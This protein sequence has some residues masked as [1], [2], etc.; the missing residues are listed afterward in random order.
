MTT[1]KALSSTTMTLDSPSH[2]TVETPTTASTTP[3]AA[4]SSEPMSRKK[5]KRSLSG[6][7]ETMNNSR[8]PSS[9]TKS[10]TKARQAAATPGA[11]KQQT[12]KQM[13]Q[14]PKESA[15]AKSASIVSVLDS[16]TAPSETTTTPPE[17]TT[18][19]DSKHD[20]ATNGNKAK[21]TMA[22]MVHDAILALKDRTGSSQIAI[23]K[24]ILATFPSVDDNN[25][26]RSRL[27]QTLK[28]GVAS[29]HFQKVK[30]SYKI[31]PEWIKKAKA[32]RA[33]EIVRKAAEKKKRDSA[34][35]A[36]S[37]KK[38]DADA[39]KNRESVSESMKESMTQEELDEIQ[40]KHDLK[41]ER[42]RLKEEMARKEKEKQERLKRRRFPMEDT[43]LHEEDKEF[44][45][46]ATVKRRPAIPYFFQIVRDSKSTAQ[47]PSRC[48][49]VDF[50]NRGLVPDL[51][52]VYHFFRGDVRFCDLTEPKM[53]CDFTLSNLIYSVDEVL[54][55]NA[56]K[57]KLVPPLLQHLFL[58]CLSLLTAPAFAGDTRE[59]KQLSRDLEELADALSPASWP[60]ICIMYMECMDRYY[61]SPASQDPS[62]LP[63]GRTDV[64]Y[65]FR[66]SDTLSTAPVPPGAAVPDGYFGY[67]GNPKSTLAKAFDKLNRQ[68]VWTL[69]AD[70]LMALLRA[71]TDD[72]I[73]TRPD[74]MVE[75]SGRCVFR[76]Q[77]L[78][79]AAPPCFE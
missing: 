66:V 77:N 46:T 12:D 6:R 8:T 64:S 73:A 29:S 41:M 59:Q 51:L 10:A 44:G 14:F 26:F 50:D 5:Q 57:S 75:I 37:N 65:L 72:V 45:I 79:C 24:Y 7:N 43:R 28:K 16:E 32:K 63:P 2:E 15:K 76:G 13:F 21:K 39:K 48:D 9:A 17:T 74:I 62:V 69:Q 18:D 49:A 70:E 11:H 34:N 52:Q 23:Q 61:K 1:A 4:E 40:R 60:E 30:A 56:R 27:G 19:N 58:C 67:F 42:Q 55:G 38:Q 20:T 33:K 78:S 35:Q 31:S 25:T 71:L 36:N 53:V 47:T 3:N 54:S 68:D 22:E